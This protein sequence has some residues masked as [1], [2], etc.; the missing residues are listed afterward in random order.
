MSLAP[1][2]YLCE[3]TV[4]FQGNDPISKNKPIALWM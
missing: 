4:K 1:C 2:D 3:E